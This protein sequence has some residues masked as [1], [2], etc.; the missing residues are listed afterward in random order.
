MAKR[1]TKFHRTVLHPNRYLIW[2]IVSMFLVAG[3]LV[4]YIYIGNINVDTELAINQNIE[5]WHTY[6][7]QYITFRYPAEWLIDP[8]TNF[9]GFGPK[10]VD[11]F[12]IYSYSSA[13]DPAYQSYLK[14]SKTRPITIDGREGIRVVDGAVNSYQRIA[15]VKN[16]T[17]L[18]ELRGTTPLFD[19]IVGTIRFLK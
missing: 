15:F 9:V 3:S 17:R 14:S 16:G 2:A 4:S 19:Q 1:K 7:D 5:F 13:S 8:G 6:R 10:D 18:Y 12:L 11:S